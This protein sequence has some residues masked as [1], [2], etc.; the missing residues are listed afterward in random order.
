MINK[1]CKDIDYKST[2]TEPKIHKKDKKN[3]KM[4]LQDNIFCCSF[5]SR[6]LNYRNAACCSTFITKH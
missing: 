1:G 5:R 2:Q 4:L 3:A 6:Y